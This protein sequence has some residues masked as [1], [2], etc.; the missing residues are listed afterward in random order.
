MNLFV[1]RLSRLGALTVLFAV[2]ASQAD[3]GNFSYNIAISGSPQGST[4]TMIPGGRPSGPGYGYG[5]GVPAPPVYG[6]PKWQRH[7]FDANTQFNGYGSNKS[8]TNGLTLK[9]PK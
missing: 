1:R 3:A 7:F 5:S 8:S 2:A 4:E 9:V 6:A